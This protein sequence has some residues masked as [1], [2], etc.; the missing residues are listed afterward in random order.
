V[1]TVIDGVCPAGS[2]SIT[3]DGTSDDGKKVASGV[4]F[5]RMESDGFNQTRKMILMK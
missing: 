1:R 3:W 5:Y 4:Y 2:H